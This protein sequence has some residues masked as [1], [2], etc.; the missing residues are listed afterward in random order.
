M[1]N[2]YYYDDIDYENIESDMDEEEERDPLDLFL[3]NDLDNV[4]DL[5]DDLKR[6][7]YYLPWTCQYFMN[8]IIDIVLYNKYRD[9][10]MYEETIDTIH[11][12]INSFLKN[13]KK[14]LPIKYIK[15][16]T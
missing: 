13:Y 14:E 12:C 2:D 6:R 1:S 3:S 8:Y 9:I 7:Y 4:L 15:C 5:Y 16:C 10:Y 11:M